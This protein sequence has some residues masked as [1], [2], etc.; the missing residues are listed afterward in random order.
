MVYQGEL[1]VASQNKLLGDFMISDLE[2]EEPGELASVTVEFDFDLDG[3]LH[4]RAR[5]R[6]TEKEEQ[7]TVKASLDRLDA[8]AVDAAR[9]E[10]GHT[11]VASLSDTAKA[12]IERGKSL[13]AREDLA[14]EGRENLR[15]L[16][17]EIEQAQNQGQ[18]ARFDELLETL[19][20]RLFDF[21]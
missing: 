12:L 9:V 17:D 20:D 10:L 21:E 5:D 2:A 13:L 19:L 6:Y 11:A 15:F 4:V 1:P 16:L 18:A 8:A 7:L 14:D 3:I